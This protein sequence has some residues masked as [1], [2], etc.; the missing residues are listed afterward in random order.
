MLDTGMTCG[1]R[2]EYHSFFFRERTNTRL[3]LQFMEAQIALMK[4]GE[5]WIGNWLLQKR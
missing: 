4:K 2:L 5:A 3:K 1:G